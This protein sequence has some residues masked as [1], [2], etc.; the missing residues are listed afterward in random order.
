MTS[1]E[2][3]PFFAIGYIKSDN[4][5][6]YSIF[7]LS[8]PQL[9]IPTSLQFLPVHFLQENLSEAV[10]SAF[11]HSHTDI[12]GHHVAQPLTIPVPDF[13]FLPE[14]RHPVFCG[15]KF[16]SFISFAIRPAAWTPLLEQSLT[17]IATSIIGR[18]PLLM[19]SIP[20]SLSTTI[21]G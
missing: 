1:H 19:C 20:A 12:P 3:F 13:E 16:N 14:L 10:W 5:S 2:D 7:I 4:I 6:V 11:H 15:L 18:I 8:I 9:T 17:R 21:Y